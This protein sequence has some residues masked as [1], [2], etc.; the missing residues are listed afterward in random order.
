MLRRQS[1]ILR[2]TLLL[3]LLLYSVHNIE[4]KCHIFSSH[5]KN[6]SIMLP[7]KSTTAVALLMAWH[8]LI[9][10]SKYYFSNFQ[11]KFAKLYVLFSFVIPIVATTAVAMHRVLGR[12][13]LQ[14]L[15]RISSITRPSV[16]LWTGDLH[17]RYYYMAHSC[18]AAAAVGCVVSREMAFG[19]YQSQQLQWNQR[20]SLF[21]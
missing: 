5:T 14:S 6:S 15:N 17:R 9:G 18:L 16:C 4:E 2:L 7:Y 8:L 1:G 13:L 3:L 12:Y 19:E 10:K 21:Q 20:A 11:L